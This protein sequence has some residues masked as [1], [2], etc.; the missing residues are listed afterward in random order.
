ML[1]ND[2]SNRLGNSYSNL[3][4][5]NDNKIVSKFSLSSDKLK[6]KNILIDLIN[7]QT[8]FDAINKVIISS[9]IPSYNKRLFSL[10]KSVCN[11]VFFI[12]DILTKIDIGF[13]VDNVKEVG[14]DR[15][16]NS[17]YAAEVIK[18][19][20]IVIDFGTA[21]TFDFISK[22]RVYLGGLIMPGIRL[23]LESLA[24]K[25]EKL[26]NVKFT[27]F[28]ELIGKNTSDAIRAGILY[29]NLYYDQLCL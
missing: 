5:F 8:I 2:I 4:I 9:V 22:S 21:T 25:T 23:S 24:E 20:C 17:F 19:N 13:E 18:D 12:E 16:V 27:A 3:A 15:I 10:A 6:S 28:D 26:N 14:S 29:G 1:L 7:D 11:N